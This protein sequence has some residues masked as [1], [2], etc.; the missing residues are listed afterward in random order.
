MDILGSLCY[1]TNLELFDMQPRWSRKGEPAYGI[2][3]SGRGIDVQGPGGDGEAKSRRVKKV[4]SRW[5]C[6]L[7][8]LLALRPL[9]PLSPIRVRDSPRPS[10]S[11]AKVGGVRI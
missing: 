3:G 6:Q 4:L 1:A 7:C 10:L 11:N 2:V 9:G 5:L 8:Q